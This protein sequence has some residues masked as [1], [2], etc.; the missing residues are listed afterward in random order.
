MRVSE[1]FNTLMSIHFNNGEQE[2]R[3]SELFN[4]LMSI[5][6]NN[7]E[8]EVRVSE[9]F[10]TLMSIH[11]NNGE[12]EVRVSE[13]LTLNNTFTQDLVCFRTTSSRSQSKSIIQHFL[14]V[15]L[16]LNKRIIIK[17]GDNTNTFIM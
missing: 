2:V 10:N 12:Q 15:V 16:V 6:F 17:Y 3:V 9:L 1:L 8:Q 14:V 11:F 13:F 5:L 7:G 4:T